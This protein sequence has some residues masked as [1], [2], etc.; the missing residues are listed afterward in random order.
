MLLA[1]M[2]NICKNGIEINL[3]DTPG[4]FFKI[5]DIVKDASAIG[6]ELRSIKILDKLSDGLENCDIL[7][8]LDHIAR[9][10]S[11]HSTYLDFYFIQLL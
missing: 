5:K 1:S 10:L 3:F 9:Y 6:G 8:I 11:N 7:I 4:H 2:K